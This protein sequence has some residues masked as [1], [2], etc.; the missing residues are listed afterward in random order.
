MS[1]ICSVIATASPLVSPEV[2]KKIQANLP[3]EAIISEITLAE[4][5][6]C[7]WQ[8]HDSADAVGL[9][10]FL[11]SRFADLAADI[12]VFE[13]TEPRRKKL[14]LSDMDATIVVGETLD[15][16]AAYADLGERVA[17]IT[18]RA[19]NGEISFHEALRERVGLLKGLP[20]SA[21]ETVLAGMQLMPGAKTL[22]A[23][24]RVHGVKTALVSGG[25]KNFTH[26]VREKLGFDHDFGNV[27]QVANGLLTGTVEEPIQDKHTKQKVLHDLCERYDF[28]LLESAAVGDGAN[29][30]L[31]I[32]ASG[33]GVG[34]QPKPALARQIDI[35]I[36]H[37][38]LSALLYLQGYDKSDITHLN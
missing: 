7:E 6:A 30:M 12:N 10:A 38:D 33:L 4:G 15:E 5:H 25:F 3:P 37:S 14:L 31:M 26:V 34:F 18:A 24:L 8:L 19:M 21:I 23:T 27:L 35:H 2:I 1:L 9:R 16:L 36:D 17:A 13:A 32:G 28:S 11:R 29:D 20:S 22:L